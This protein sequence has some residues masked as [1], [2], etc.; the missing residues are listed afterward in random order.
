[1]CFL[2]PHLPDGPHEWRDGRRVFK[3]G[4]KL[5]IDGTDTL[6][7]RSVHDRQILAFM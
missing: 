3:K 5:V 1:M 6:A 2:D 4:D 7:G